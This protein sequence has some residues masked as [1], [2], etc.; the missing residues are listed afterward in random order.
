[1]FPDSFAERLKTQKYLD[2][3][4][5]LRA[6]EEPSVPSIRINR[7]KWNKNPVSGEPV[8]WCSAGYY[9]ERRPSYKADPLFHA[10]CYYPQEA[11]SMFLEE[12]YRQ[13]KPVSGKI[14]ILDL[15]GAP[16]GKSTHLSYLLGTDGWLTANDAIRQRAGILSENITK[17]GSLNTLVTWNDPSDFGNIKNFFDI[18]LVDAPCSGEG[19]FRDAEAVRQWSEAHAEHCTARQKRILMDV[20]PALRKDGVLIYSTCTFNPSENEYNIKWFSENAKAVS[21]RLDIS[22][23]DT[24]TE[25]LHQNTYGYAFYPDKV[26]GEGLFISVL[27]K[28]E[29]DKASSSVYKKMKLSIP[30]KEELSKVGEWTTCEPGSVVRF[31][32]ELIVTA[33]DAGEYSLLSRHLRII[34]PGTKVCTVKGTS[35]IPSP[36]L[37]L[38]TCL[39]KDSFPAVD[40]DYEGAV[41][42]LRRESTAIRA[43]AP[44]WNIIRYNGVN[45]GFINRTGNRVNNYFPVEWR[46]KN[47]V[48]ESEKNEIIAWK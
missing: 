42:Y 25:I 7:A 33:P 21:I 36:E 8:S 45:L 23:F 41:S 5:L 4:G 39:R 38:S 2:S 44:G 27:R 6:L 34:K 47:A 48:T 10:G 46:I 26:K 30:G 16:G 3:E 37:A 22:H 13:V 18:I 9:L 14:R 15:C 11:S 43:S 32:N 20:W 35:F 12:V 1:M 17:W 24:I 19:M 28:E 31:G 40:L 29:D